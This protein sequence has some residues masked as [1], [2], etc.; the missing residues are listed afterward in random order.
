MAVNRWQLP[1]ELG[2][3]VTGLVKLTSH[4]L[5]HKLIEVA[6]EVK[7]VNGN[8]LRAAPLPIVP[9]MGQKGTKIWNM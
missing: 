8:D 2:N 4:F 9:A 1:D 7:C 5:R 6:S 3:K